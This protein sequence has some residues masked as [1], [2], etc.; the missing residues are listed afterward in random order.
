MISWATAP[1]LAVMEHGHQ[2]MVTLSKWLRL[3]VPD[4]A[5][6]RASSAS[7]SLLSPSFTSTPS[8]KRVTVD[9]EPAVPATLPCFGFRDHPNLRHLHPRC[10]YFT[11]SAAPLC[12]PGCR[13]LASVPAF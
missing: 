13:N 4:T 9:D 5:F 8:A 11:A 10:F 7:N 6:L 12:G 3:Y 1:V 2:P